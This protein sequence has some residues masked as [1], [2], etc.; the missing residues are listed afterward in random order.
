MSIDFYK[1]ELNSIFTELDSICTILATEHDDLDEDEIY[2]KP[3][4]WDEIRNLV[5]RGNALVS[6][7]KDAEDEFRDEYGDL[8]ESDSEYINDQE[9][10]FK[11]FD[12]FLNKEILEEVTLAEL[13]EIFD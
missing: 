13:R 11:K 7:C 6:E 5:D 1:G 2:I 12:D 4:I 9:E 8:Y 3:D 10:F